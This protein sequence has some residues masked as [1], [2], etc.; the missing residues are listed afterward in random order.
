M[1][2]GVVGPGS[3]QF[4]HL[5]TILLFSEHAVVGTCCQQTYMRFSIRIGSLV[6]RQLMTA[7]DAG[8]TMGSDLIR[9]N[10]CQAQLLYLGSFVN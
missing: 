8:A 4:Q 9:I 6:I 7:D 2:P 3:P 10:V 5:F 1:F